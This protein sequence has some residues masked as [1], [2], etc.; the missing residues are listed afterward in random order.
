MAGVGIWSQRKA[1]QLGEDRGGLG[2][3]PKLEQPGNKRGGDACEIRLCQQG[4]EH[5]GSAG[6]VL[7]LKQGGRDPR[8][9][10]IGTGKRLERRGK[11][12][13]GLRP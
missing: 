6:S 8:V 3:G 7:E 4:G 12:F 5:V 2:G 1:Q 13:D 11:N 10:M 9:C